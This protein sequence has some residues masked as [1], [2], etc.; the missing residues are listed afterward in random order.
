MDVRTVFFFDA[1]V[2]P[3][4][5]TFVYWIL[6]AGIALGGLLG[7]VSAFGMM[8]F[9]PMAGIGTLVLVPIGVIVAALVAR[10]YCEI[11]IVLFKMHEC[12][13]DIRGSK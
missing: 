11:M 2:T 12:L 10:M 8:R 4:V 1:M 3:K 6:L 9:E 7:I 13:N 5:I